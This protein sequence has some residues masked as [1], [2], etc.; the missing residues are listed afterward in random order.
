MALKTSIPKRVPLS[1]SPKKSP[2][3]LTLLDLIDIDQLVNEH[4]E[5]VSVTTNTDIH[6][7]DNSKGTER[8]VDEDRTKENILNV[9]IDEKLTKSKIN[10]KCS[11]CRK[12]FTDLNKL[13]EHVKNCFMK[14]HPCKECDLKF[15]TESKL[16]RHVNECHLLIKEFECKDCE[17]SFAR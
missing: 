6:Q 2:K 4:A 13:K 8:N 17:K 10:R 1:R 14:K 3:K 15:A 11:Y 12:G 16:E 9:D 7:K 5:V